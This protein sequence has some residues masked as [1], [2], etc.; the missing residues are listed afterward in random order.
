LIVV[1]FV[2]M[3]PMADLPRNPLAIGLTFS[4]GG[5]M[6]GEIFLIVGVADPAPAAELSF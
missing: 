3:L 6:T 1:C 2:L 5:S 4:F